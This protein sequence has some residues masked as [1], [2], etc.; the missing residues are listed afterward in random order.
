MV[1][2][3]IIYGIVS[4]FQLPLL[5]DGDGGDSGDSQTGSDRR[6]NSS[7]DKEDC[8]SKG[9]SKGSSRDR[10]FPRYTHSAGE[11]FDFQARKHSTTQTKSRLPA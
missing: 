9:S 6:D 1:D 11:Q 5:P 10:N 8:N 2:E 4:V 7:S 3:R